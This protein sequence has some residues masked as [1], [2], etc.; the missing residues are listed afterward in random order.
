MHLTWYGTAGFRC[1]TGEQAWLID[2]YLSRNAAARPRLHTGPQDV[3]GSVIFLSH[4]HFD[5]AYDVPAIARRSG[6]RVHCSHEVAQALQRHGVPRE[7]I[8]VA[9]AGDHFGF[10]AYRA[11]CLPAAHV[12]FDVRLIARTLLR[13]LPALPSLLRISRRWP[14]GPVLAWRFTLVE[15]GNCVLQHL[16][17]AVDDPA[18]LDR[19]ARP[20]RPDVLLVPVQ[21]HSD[22]QRIAARIVARLQPQIAIPHHHDNFYPPLSQQVDVAD[23]VGRVRE[24][25][26][27][28]EVR[29]LPLGERVELLREEG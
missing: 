10:G 6:A 24:A 15:E 27:G 16:G 11:T 2:P 5:H 29:E 12:Q 4:G 22:I 25:A 26:P 1:E 3:N 13:A 14:Q 23:F 8:V 9:H 20:E 17:S 28:I 19:L 21:G 18:A 7:Q